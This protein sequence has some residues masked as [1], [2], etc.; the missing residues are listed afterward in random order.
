MLSPKHSRNYPQHH[1][2]SDPTRHNRPP[3]SVQC[4]H[5]DRTFY[6]VSQHVATLQG[7]VLHAKKL[8]GTQQE[9][10]PPA[11]SRD[12]LTAGLAEPGLAEHSRSSLPVPFYRCRGADQFM[13]KSGARF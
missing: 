6:F 13:R 12:W 1:H 2:S 3:C 7:E 5:Q 9:S 11:E 10:L 4:S 8:S